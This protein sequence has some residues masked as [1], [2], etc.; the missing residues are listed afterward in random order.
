MSV[1]L[2]AGPTA[3]G[4][5]DV[6][7]TLAKKIDAEIICTDSMQVY[8]RMN[9]GTA[10][11]T[12]EEMDG[13]KHYMIDKLEPNVNCS[14]AW[15]KD[16]VKKYI[17]DINSRGK[18]AIL[19]GGTGF[20]INA[21][22]FDTTFTQDTNKDYKQELTEFTNKFGK[23]A[24]FE[25]LC[26]IDPE[27]AGKIHPNNIKR[28]IRAIEYFYQNNETIS[29]H[30]TSQKYKR[31][32]DDSPYNY[33]YFVLDM[34]R[35]LLYNRI[36]KRIDIMVKNGLV[37][38]VRELYNDGLTEDMASIKAIGYKEFYPYFRGEITYET[39]I[40][41]LK[42]NTRRFAK[43]QITWFKHQATPIFIPVDEYGFDK[44]EISKFILENI[45]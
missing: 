16:E 14:V 29:S 12:K 44:Y 23:E 39:A 24:L 27:S 20:Y 43:R 5:T 15:F 28:I 6:S 17:N 35:E 21:I 2:I 30:N 8:K 26:E 37:D 38:E 36:N 32:A 18:T 25:K 41:N 1:I 45:K 11:V 31:L 40:E 10:K 34:K 33:Y 42:I 4:K 9:I 22:L 13:I 3:S 19:V 7:V